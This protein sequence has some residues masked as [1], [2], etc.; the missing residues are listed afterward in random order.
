MF[1][2]KMLSSRL[3][4]FTISPSL[5]LGEEAEASPSIA[6][7]KHFVARLNDVHAFGYN[8]G[9]S[10]RIWMKFGELRVYCLELSRQRERETKFCFFCPLNN[11]RF[12]RLPVGQISRNFAQKDVLPCP[13]VSFWKTFMKICP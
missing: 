7:C 9:G 5:L 8:S 3:K 10:E 13:H 6:K 1:A 2:V 4:D 11:A 12:H